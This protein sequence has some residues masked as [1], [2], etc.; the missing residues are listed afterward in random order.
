MTIGSQTET[1]PTFATVPVAVTADQ[2]AN[3]MTTFIESGLSRFWCSGCYLETPGS[4]VL[5]APGSRIWYANAG[6]YAADD[7]MI[8]VM[9]DENET[10]DPEDGKAHLISKKEFTAGLIA[11]AT[12]ENGAYAHHF[13]DIIK[14]EG[15]AATAD[16][17]MQF[18]LFGKEV[19]A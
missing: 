18:V 19:Y 3:Q 17:L 11:L 14:D 1:S 4:Y 8:R 10:G 9:E 16:I 5:D 12:A 15:D 6:L 2:I 7:W 13:N